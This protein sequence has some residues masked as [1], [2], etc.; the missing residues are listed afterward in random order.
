M[1]RKKCIQKQQYFGKKPL[2]SQSDAGPSVKLPTVRTGIDI[3]NLQNYQI[4][5]SLRTQAK[6]KIQV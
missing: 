3:V 1:G 5:S 4:K 2:F 6:Q